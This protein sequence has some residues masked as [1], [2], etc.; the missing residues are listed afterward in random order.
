MFKQTILFALAIFFSTSFSTFASSGGI[1]GSFIF[2]SG[3]GTCHGSANTATSVSLRGNN[4]VKAGG[5]LDLTAIVA[6][7]TETGAGINITFLN[8]DNQVT[9]GLAVKTGQGL[10]A[11]GNQLTHNGPKQMSFGS[12]SF[13]FTLTA[14]TTPGNYKIIANGNAINFNGNSNGD[15]WNKSSEFTITVLDTDVP[16]LSINNTNLNCGTVEVGQT[17]NTVFQSI[18]NNTSSVDI[19]ILTFETFSV[20][21]SNK[22]QFEIGPAFFPLTLKAGESISLDV[23]FT[24]TTTSLSEIELRIIT[25]N[26]VGSIPPIRIFGNDPNTSVVNNNVRGY[27][28]VSKTAHNGL[29]TFDITTPN[30]QQNIQFSIVDVQGNTIYNQDI[31][32]SDL[33]KTL[34]WNPMYNG[35]FIAI[36]KSNNSILSTSKFQVVK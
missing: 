30:N 24:P 29:V 5:T 20:N 7:S 28:I 14:P 23:Q 12:A 11:G 10:R 21:G 19:N 25:E 33:Q 3:C 35:S 18:I 6:N 8:E 16:N 26:A 17:K 9:P 31:L 34:Q 15:Q 2:Q 22:G 4:K 36:V 13:D 1:T 32:S 27:S